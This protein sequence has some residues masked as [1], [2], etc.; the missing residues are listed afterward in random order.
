MIEYNK[1]KLN[2][3]ELEMAQKIL[4]EVDKSGAETARLMNK[5]K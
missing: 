5:K 4:R 3:G 1:P 2:N